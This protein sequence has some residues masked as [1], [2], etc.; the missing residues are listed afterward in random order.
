MAM[1]CGRVDGRFQAARGAISETTVCEYHRA[2]GGPRTVLDAGLGPA[3]AGQILPPSRTRTQST[4][5]AMPRSPV[6][7]A[8]LV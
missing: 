3:L 8:D 2:R 7:S 5:S 1:G 6:A 4:T